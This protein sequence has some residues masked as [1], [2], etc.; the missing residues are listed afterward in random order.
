MHAHI[1]LV[2]NVFFIAFACGLGFGGG[3]TF[4]NHPTSLPPITSPGNLPVNLPNNLPPLPSP[5]DIPDIPDNLQS[6]LEDLPTE[7]PN[8]EDFTSLLDNL[9]EDLPFEDL[10]DLRSMLEDMS[11]S[12]MPDLGDFRSIIEEMPFSE[13]PNVQSLLDNLPEDLPFEDL[14]DLRSIL[15]NMPLSEMPDLG[16]LQSLLDGEN[17]EELR[18]IIDNLDPNL[19]N[20]SLV[21]SLLDNFS[22]VFN[23]FGENSNSFQVSNLFNNLFKPNDNDEPSSFIPS[24]IFSPMSPSSESSQDS[25]EASVQCVLFGFLLSV[26]LLQF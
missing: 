1:L 26:I 23:N 4:G 18:S 5:G 20:L 10:D 22:S 12:E 21:E 19:Q 17:M 6:F 15:E 11:L 25:S 2:L 8:F 16:E 24:S 13:M 14:D 9:P 3:G 7:M